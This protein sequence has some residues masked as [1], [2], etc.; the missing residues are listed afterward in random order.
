MD[1]SI[2]Q[3]T[4]RQIKKQ[5]LPLIS[6]IVPIYNV[7]FY[8]KNCIT[9]I[10]NQTYVNLE[11]ILIN[12]G[13]TD[14]SG[15]ICD[16]YADHDSRIIVIHKKNAGL[17]NARNTG[18]QM[19]K[20]NYIAFID[21][22]DYIHPQMIETLHYYLAKEPSCDF[23]MINFQTTYDNPPVNYDI[24][25][26]ENLSTKSLSQNEL[27][28]GLFSVNTPIQ[29]ILLFFAVHCKLYRKQIIK[30]TIFQN[31]VLSEDSEYNSRLYLK[32][33]K[34]IYVDK[35]LY[36]YVQ[37]NSSAIHQKYNINHV[38]RIK[39][40]HTCYNNIPNDMPIIKSWA[41]ERLYK[42]MINMRYLIR[43]TDN[44]IKN[45]TNR[46]IRDIREETSIYLKKDSTLSFP[47]KYG[48]LIFTYFPFIYELFILLN[49]YKAK[50]R[51]N[52]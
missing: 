37:R 5:V 24:I 47:R 46:L 9:S 34:A 7:E 1:E 23:S 33:K 26:P 2:S 15:K 31:F 27:F 44:E 30:D 42:F 11:I 51:N 41:L 17:S 20:G 29:N 38:N 28:G 40:Y 8:L 22:D 32:C 12:D 10:I 13:S 48:L 21:G 3:I 18:I 43:N 50:F 52:D 19:A 39:V 49:E 25:Q 16:E 36:F 4:K 14:N 6:I 35:P 45:Y